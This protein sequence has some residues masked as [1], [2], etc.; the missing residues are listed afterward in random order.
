[1][2]RVFIRDSSRELN[3]LIQLKGKFERSCELQRLLKPEIKNSYKCLTYIYNIHSYHK[4]EHSLTS[5]KSLI[6][7]RGYVT[8]WYQSMV[9]TLSLIGLM[10]KFHISFVRT[11]PTKS[12][13]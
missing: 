12:N 5:R 13:P 11:T 8:K 3:E 2:D 1:M 10:H 9:T 6:F 4:I 7:G